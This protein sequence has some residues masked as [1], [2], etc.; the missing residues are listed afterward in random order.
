MF[1][2]LLVP[3]DGSPIAESALSTAQEIATR[4]D[5]QI[6]LF[7]VIDSTHIL[8]S[9]EL[10]HSEAV[11]SLREQADQMIRDYLRKIKINLSQEGHDVKVEIISGKSVAEA[12]LEAVNKLEMD[13]I[14]MCTHGR[15]GLQRWVYGSV[16]DKIL[17]HATIPVVLVRAPDEAFELTMP[18]IEDLEAIRSHE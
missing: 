17:K 8:P 1:K 10:L 2:H 5:G 7:H 18:A 11:V 14:V 4:F 3:L 9:I 13:A 16:A 12:I 6:T 15:G